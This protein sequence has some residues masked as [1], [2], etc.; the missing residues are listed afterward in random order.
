MTD[1]PDAPVG[2]KRPPR[3]TRFRPGQSGNP[4][5]RPKGTRDLATDLAEELSERISVQDGGRRVRVSKQRALL[6]AL[7]EKALS[8]DTRAA[9]IVLQLVSRVITSEVVGVAPSDD[10]L[11]VDDRAILDRFIA[12]QLAARK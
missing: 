2:Y 4:R 7:V 3:H 8:G 11:S 1:D 5:G 9:G 10:T 6:K 12:E